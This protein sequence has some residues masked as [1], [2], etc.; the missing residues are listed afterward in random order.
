MVVT[1]VPRALAAALIVVA[2]LSPAATAASAPKPDPCRNRTEL[3]TQHIIDPA[4]VS[5]VAPVG[6]QTGSGGVLAV[7]SYVFPKQELRGKRLAIRAPAAMTLFGASYYLPPGAP[8][9]YKPEY[10][11][12]FSAPC[13][14][15]VKFFHIKGIS[16]RLGT[17]VPKAPSASSASQRVKPLPVAAGEQIGWYEPAVGSVAF[18]FWV[19][20]LAKQNSFISPKRYAQSNARYA[21]CP[22]QFYA[23]PLRSVWMAKLGDQGGLARPGTSCGVVTQGTRGSVLGQWFREPNVNLPVVDRLTMD[24]SYQSQAMVTMESSGSVRLGG[25]YAPQALIVGRTGSTAAGWSDPRT[26]TAGTT[27]CFSD[28]NRAVHLTLQSATTLRATVTPSCSSAVPTNEW[29]TYYR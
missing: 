19:D 14:L 11:L 9:G 28:G 26:I 20:D 10:S 24:G 29:R 6:G 25:F 18:D 2:L 27:R 12:Y 17:V 15:E 22:W 1:F 8:A 16:S 4:A 5:G 23:K 21:V 7:R 13:S 3:F